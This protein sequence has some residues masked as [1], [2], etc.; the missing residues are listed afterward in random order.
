[1]AIGVTDSVEPD[2]LRQG[3]KKHLAVFVVFIDRLLPITPW[4]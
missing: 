2:H 3:A 4:K 1:M